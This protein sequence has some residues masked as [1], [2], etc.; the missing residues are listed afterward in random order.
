M[1]CMRLPHSIVFFTS[2]VIVL[3]TSDLPAVEIIGHR[4]ASYDAPENT[5]ASV[6]LAWQLNADAVEIDIYLTKDEKIVAYHDKTTKR[7]GGRDQAV[8]EQTFA[9]LQTLDVGA[10]KNSKYKHERIPTL[11]QILNTIP[12]NKRLFIEIKCGAEVLPQLKQDLDASGKAAAQTVIIGFDYETMQQAK[13]IFPDLK[14]YW[15]FKVKQNKLTRKW[16][17]NADYY[18]QKATDAHLDGL[19]VGYNKFVT[20]EFI[21]RANSAGLP[22]YV[23]TVNSVKDAKK[24][25]NM[26]VEGITSDR[27]GLL[28]SAFKPEK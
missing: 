22:V 15:V 21:K 17:H 3:A 13:Q 18:I 7:I 25:V 11:T 1:S 26:G 20:K 6:N 19:D 10:W 12:D 14:V 2:L 4:G 27:P 5:L 8:K 16:A 24:L 9:E 28:N 23:W